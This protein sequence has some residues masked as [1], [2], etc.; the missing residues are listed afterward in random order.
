MSIF[1]IIVQRAN[2]NKVK[3]L[4]TKTEK[5]YVYIIWQKKSS[6]PEKQD[7]MYLLKCGVYMEEHNF[8]LHMITWSLVKE[9]TIESKET[10]TL[11]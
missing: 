11:R 1:D 6:T 8:T 3:P 7:A 2:M 5:V 10:E 9:E 4:K